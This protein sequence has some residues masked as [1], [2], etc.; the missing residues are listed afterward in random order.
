MTSLVRKLPEGAYDV[1]GDVHGE[2]EPLRDL[3]AVLGY[4]PGCGVHPEGR[5]LVFVGDLFD[6]G[7][8]S[9]AVFRLVRKLVE[10][11]RAR[12][13][14]GNHELNLLRDE[15]KHGNEWFFGARQRLDN[16]DILPQRLADQ[17]LRDELLAFLRQRPLVWHSDRLRVVHACWDADAV[18][19]LDGEQDVVEAC[20][21]FERSVAA[22]VRDEPDEVERGLHQQNDNPV[23]LI[24]SGREGRAARSFQAG[25]KQR[26][27][28][29]VRWWN[30]YGDAIPVVFG[31]YWRSPVPGEP[32]KSAGPPVFDDD[33]EPLAPLGPRANAWCVD[34]C[35]AVR[36]ELRL[37]G[38]SFR[39]VRLGAA[40][41]TE[42]GA[43]LG[44]RTH[45]SDALPT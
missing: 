7:P 39:A 29:R 27:A 44:V 20:A 14:L 38:G 23:K 15:R 31:H 26:W 13:V 33:D 34:Y 25:G 2:I 32:M 35:I 8:D 10:E 40:R 41:F 16:G 22:R 24:T 42:G 1:V 4:D 12:M 5:S 9:P 11:G 3:L 30:D 17:A 37:R 45:R 6:R 19:C 21:R 36:S 43:P 18:Q 28:Q